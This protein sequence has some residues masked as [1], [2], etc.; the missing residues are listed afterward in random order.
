MN[1][2]N[3]VGFLDFL[4][5]NKDLPGSDSH[6]K[7]APKLNNV[8]FR[9]FKPRGDAKLSS[10]MILLAEGIADDINVVL[11]VRNHKL[12]NHG[13]QISFPGGRI[14]LEET[15]LDAAYRETMEEIGVARCD[16]EF[17]TELSPLYVPPSNNTIFPYVGRLKSRGFAINQSEVDEVFEVPISFLKNPGNIILESRV[18]D[19]SLVTIPCWDLQKPE[20]LWGATAMILSELL[21]LYTKYE[22][23][24]ID[25]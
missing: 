25:L 3:L 11:T 24:K 21:Y 17:I 6:F 4:R 8:T 5:R 23:S 10:V 7:L 9:N 1:A 15:R 16:I 2:N 12:K 20:K 18:M 13:G 14:E 22:E 19:N